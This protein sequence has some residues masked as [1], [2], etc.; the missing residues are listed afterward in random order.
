MGASSHCAP[1]SDG[2][3]EPNGMAVAGVFHLDECDAPGWYANRASPGV[4]EPSKP[5]LGDSPLHLLLKHRWI[6][7]LDLEE[8]VGGAYSDTNLHS[9][10]VTPFPCLSRSHTLVP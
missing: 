9:P 10:I 3:T 7:D 4:G 5:A 1:R 8:F 2:G 6:V